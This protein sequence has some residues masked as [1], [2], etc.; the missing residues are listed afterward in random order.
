MNTINSIGAAGLIAC[1]AYCFG[2]LIT[3]LIVDAADRHHEPLETKR[4]RLICLLVPL[5]HALFGFLSAI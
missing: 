4:N 1:L 5:I 3:A 2:L